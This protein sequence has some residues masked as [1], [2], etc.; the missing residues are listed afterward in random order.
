MSRARLVDR[1]LGALLLLAAIFLFNLLETNLEALFMASRSPAAARLSAWGDA[2]ATA[3]RGIESALGLAS[4]LSFAAHDEAP[5]TTVVAYSASYFFLFPAL[6]LIVALVLARRKEITPFRVYSLALA[7]DYAVSLPF[8]LLLPV[9]ERW[10]HPDSG[11]ML[12]SDRLGSWLI[13]MLRPMS[14]LDNCFPSFHVSM[15]TI[16]VLVCFRFGAKMRMAALGLGA[17]VALS[18]VVLGIHWVGDVLAGAAVATL[19]V[20][21]AAWIDARLVVARA[22]AAAPE[23]QAQRSTG[24]ALPGLG[25]AALPQV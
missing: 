6:C 15:T 10:A 11:A 1:K 22:G 12:L 21:V 9:P 14:G 16:A 7:V 4:S 24:M 3:S 18:T 23:P 13:D 17:T 8:F 5:M 25:A 19:S 2:F 20:A